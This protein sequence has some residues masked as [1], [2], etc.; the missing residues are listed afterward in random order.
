MGL[1]AYAWHLDGA[2]YS[3]NAEL[4]RGSQDGTTDL[5]CPTCGASKTVAGS[6]GVEPR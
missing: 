2:P 3:K 4:R 1:V 5:R 6:E